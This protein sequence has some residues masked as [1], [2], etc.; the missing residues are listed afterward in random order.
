[1]RVRCER[2]R[3]PAVGRSAPA[4]RGPLAGCGPQ[5]VKVIHHQ[6]A[7]RQLPGRAGPCRP[8]RRGVRP[9]DRRADGM[10]PPGTYGCHPGT[11]QATA[12]AAMKWP[13][14][15]AHSRASL[16]ESLARITPV[17]TR[18]GVR[19]RPDPRELRTALYQR[20]PSRAMSEKQAGKVLRVVSGQTT[21][22]VKAVKVSRS[23]HA[24][25][26]AATAVGGVLAGHDHASRFPSPRLA[27]IWTGS[28]AAPAARN[29]PRTIGSA[30]DADS[31]HCSC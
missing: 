5:P 11:Q 15:A 12:C 28:P 6:E 25:T 17:L 7:R 27:P 18:S 2:V 14:L 20:R 10:E 4:V 29:L 30:R 24:A 19:D 21:G 31:K 9:A 13:S 16:A 26:H 22:Y 3:D 8:D 23:R 1:M